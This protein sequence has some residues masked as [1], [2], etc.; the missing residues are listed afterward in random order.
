MLAL[1]DI[2]NHCADDKSADGSIA[3][4]WA[5]DIMRDIWHPGMG[6]GAWYN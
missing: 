6:S 3:W 1:S 5:I 2:S 4:M